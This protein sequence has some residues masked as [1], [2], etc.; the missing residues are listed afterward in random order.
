LIKIK[1]ELPMSYEK[2]GY[3]RCDKCNEPVGESDRFL[4]INGERIC[5]NCVNEMMRFA[6]WEDSDEAD[7]INREAHRRI[8]E[9]R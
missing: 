2:D 4:V 6:C 3:F 1:G 5:E 7:E 9:N 8:E